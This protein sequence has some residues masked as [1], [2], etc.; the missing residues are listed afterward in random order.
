M[1]V[2][3]EKEEEYLHTAE[4]FYF[5]LPH[6]EAIEILKETG[7]N[8]AFLVRNNGQE[9]PAY[10]LCMKNKGCIY[11]LPILYVLE[12]YYFKKWIVKVDCGSGLNSGV[13]YVKS[14]LDTVKFEKLN[15]LVT[16]YVEGNMLSRT[17]NKNQCKQDASKSHKEAL[18]YVSFLSFVQGVPNQN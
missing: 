17:L 4:W 3:K 9:G 2:I 18:S 10:E 13:D 7:S 16:Y 11:I 1:K 5:D 8:K 14:G 6:Q 12:K 15:E